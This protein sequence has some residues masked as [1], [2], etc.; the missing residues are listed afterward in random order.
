M[1]S[2]PMILFFTSGT[3][4]TPFSCEAS[5]RHKHSSCV[6]ARVVTVGNPKMVRHCHG[7]PLAHY[8]TGRY[9]Q[10]PLLV[11]T[12]YFASTSA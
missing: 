6:R 4:G 7:Y 12:T 8:V 10:V 2:D 1:L 5:L 9:V 3:T 11:C